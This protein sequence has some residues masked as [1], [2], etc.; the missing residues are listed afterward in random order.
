MERLILAS[1]SAARV[2]MLRAAGVTFSVERPA[3]DEVRLRAGM[4]AASSEAVATA[5]AEA[6][7]LAVSARF[8]DA[9]T[10]GAD[11]ILSFEDEIL[12]KCASLAEA[13]A[14]LR[15][16]AG[17]SHRLSSAVA[18]AR[19]GRVLWGCAETAQLS[20][21]PLSDEF[22]DAYLAAEG[23]ELLYCVGCY[24]LE[25]RG[26]QLFDKIEGDYFV[27]LGLPLLPLL[28]ALRRYGG[29]AV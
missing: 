16:M 6:K 14:L 9:L 8:P 26:M 7:A 2:Q 21:R 10:I 27:V 17:K 29:I 5:L 3:V 11:Q 4:P 19:G 18:V 24:R 28:A 15:R 20:V 25:G 22:L 23:E 13:R 1:G 12:G